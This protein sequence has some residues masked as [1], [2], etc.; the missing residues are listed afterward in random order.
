MK[1][2]IFIALISLACACSISPRQIDY[3]KE[4]CAFCKMNIV[5]QKH[6]AQ[7]VTSKGKIYCYDALECMLNDLHNYA[8]NAPAH[9]LTNTLNT[10]STLS[11][12]H[13]CSFLISEKLPS[14]MGGNLN[15]FSD[16]NELEKALTT[17]GGKI[18]NWE[19]LTDKYSK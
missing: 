17:N 2:L 19:Q 14:P 15:A 7:L 16:A 1:H 12:V 13:N 6:A 18:Y 9:L 8:D 3:G 4:A 11:N 5:D 10:P